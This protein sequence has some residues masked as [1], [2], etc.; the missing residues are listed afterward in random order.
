MKLVSTGLLFLAMATTMAFFVELKNVEPLP[1][2]T[3]K[4]HPIEHA[5]IFH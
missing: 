5:H 3:A 4:V 1:G 2:T